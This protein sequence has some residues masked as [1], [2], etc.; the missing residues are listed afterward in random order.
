MTACVGGSWSETDYQ[1]KVANAAEAARSSV[2][3]AR[4]VVEA[5]DEGKALGPYTARALS[6]AETSLASVATQFG[7]VQPPTTRST[8]LRSEVAS[9]LEECRT[10]LGDLRI[11]ARDGH[12]DELTALAEPLPRLAGQLQRLQRLRAT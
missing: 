12:F 9:L 7:S 10:A 6:D 4:L 11:A 2:Q 3:T 8:V 5:V 1:E